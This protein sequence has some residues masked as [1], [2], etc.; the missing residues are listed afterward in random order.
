MSFRFQRVNTRPYFIPKIPFVTSH[1]C[2]CHMW[3]ISCL[4]YVNMIRKQE[5]MNNICQLKCVQVITQTTNQAY[6]HHPFPFSIHNHHCT[7]RWLTPTLYIYLQFAIHRLTG[8]GTKERE[9]TEKYTAYYT[10]P[11]LIKIKEQITSSTNF[12]A[13]FSLFIDNMFVTLLSSTCF[14]H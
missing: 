4:D 2:F 3:A 7:S 1:C 12:N 14:E 10:L 11:V 9:T 5:V 8:W 6:P 13:Q